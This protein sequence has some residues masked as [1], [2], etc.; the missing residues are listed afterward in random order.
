[1]AYAKYELNGKKLLNLDNI[2]MVDYDE[3]YLIF[4]KSIGRRSIITDKFIS[5]QNANMLENEPN[6]NYTVLY[7][8]FLEELKSIN[9]EMYNQKLM[10]YK[11][12]IKELNEEENVFSEEKQQLL[13]KG[14]PFDKRFKKYGYYI[15]KID[16]DYFQYKLITEKNIKIDMG[17]NLLPQNADISSYQFVPITI[18]DLQ[19]MEMNI[20]NQR[21]PGSKHFR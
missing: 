18:E 17:D 11:E 13:I 2:G 1:M 15:I 3:Y 9:P 4:N 16:N 5:T 6:I 19:E 20:I 12:Y 21:Q 14:Y 10:F 7:S 8:R